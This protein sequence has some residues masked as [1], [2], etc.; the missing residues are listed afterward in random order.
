MEALILVDLQNDFC[1]GGALAVP[2]GD[3]VVPLANRLMEKFDLVIA[4]QDW[5]PADHGSFAP[6]HPGR[7]AGEVVELNGR[8]Q[9]LW[10][11][12]CVQNTRG[13]DFHPQLDLGRIRKIVHKGTDPRIDS[14]STFF[15]NAHRRSTGLADYLK[16]HIVDRVYLA[17]LAT[18]YCVKFSAMD[19]RQLGLETF[20]IEDA[21]RGI[22]LHAGDVAASLDE[23]RRA[24]AKLIRT[25]EILARPPRE[26]QVVAAGRFARFVRRGTWEFVQRTN[27]S[28]V[29][30]IIA[31][32]ADGKLLLVEQYRPPLE[33]RCVELPAGLVGDL[34]GARDEDLALAAKR[35]L[36][37]ETGYEA[38]DIEHLV[39][40]VASAGLTDEVLSL[41]R[42][43]GLTKKS[44]GGGDEHEEITV[45]EVPLANVPAWMKEQAGRGKMLD[46]KVYTALYFVARS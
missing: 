39:D 38:A 22:D 13:A 9:I 36:L 6:C 32:T 20:V 4:T 18:D 1:P 24:G 15:D 31:V 10:P 12:H 2:D 41:V 46:L 3:A 34:A 30:G 17:G 21:C 29:V 16:R 43:T 25:D 19:A 11:A 28:G 33:R 5:H 27:V 45:H 7:E 42:A 23:M 40:G 35:E 8:P 26:P 44:D 37:E 14:Y